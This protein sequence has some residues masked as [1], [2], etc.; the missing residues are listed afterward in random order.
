MNLTQTLDRY[1]IARYAIFRY[2]YRAGILKSLGFS[3]VLASLTGLLAQVRIP[4]PFTPVPISGQV[5][6]VLLSGVLLGRIYGGLSQVFYL[7]LGMA[8][9]PWFSGGW[10]GLPVGP[11][12]GYIF[13]FVAAAFVVGWFT[14]RYIGMRG[15]RGQLILM[16]LG[17]SIIYFFGAIQFAIVMRSGLWATLAGAVLPFIPLDIAKAAL[18]AGLTSALLPKASYNGE[19]DRSRYCARY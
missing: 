10:G 6:G 17:V 19:V 2:R 8:G 12:G 15:F 11:T 14:D 1:R 13:G 4:L 18:A 9:I 5:F 16:L 3:L 7:G